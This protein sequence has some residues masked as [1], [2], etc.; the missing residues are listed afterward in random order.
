MRDGLPSSLNGGSASSLLLRASQL[1][2]QRDF[3][4][5]AAE[6]QQAAARF[7]A[8][9][10][11]TALELL[12]LA[13]LEEASLLAAADSARAKL[14]AEAAKLE[15]SRWQGLAA[16]WTEQLAAGHAGH[17]QAGNRSS[18]EVAAVQRAFQSVVMPTLHT[19]ATISGDADGL[20]GAATVLH[21]PQLLRCR[22]AW[23]D[24]L[25]AACVRTVDSMGPAGTAA[26]SEAR[27]TD[28]G[29]SVCEGISSRLLHWHSTMFLAVAGQPVDKLG[30]DSRGHHPHNESLSSSVELPVP[31]LVTVAVA[32][33]PNSVPLRVG[34]WRL[35]DIRVGAHEGPPAELVPALMQEFEA[36]LCSDAFARLHPLQQAALAMSE[37][38]WIHPFGD[39]NGRVARLLGAAITAAHGWPPLTLP[40][41]VREIYLN[42]AAV[43]HPAGG[44]CTAPMVQLLAVR[45]VEQIGETVSWLAAQPEAEAAVTASDDAVASEGI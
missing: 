40:A 27:Q 11:A 34:A 8:P 28:A 15:P 31:E 5:A 2:Q 37:L 9:A 4:A 16:I 19:A 38:L 21:G 32:A 45:M 26:A 41:S 29:Q 33:Q 42:A 24:V 7:H 44:G 25:A 35:A 43:S 39:G 22:Y 3:I 6:A 14:A 1:R 23:F 12:P 10:V 17:R 20:S 13:M 30:N 18:A 36:W